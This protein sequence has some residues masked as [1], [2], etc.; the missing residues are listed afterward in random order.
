MALISKELQIY[1]SFLIESYPTGLLKLSL[2]FGLLISFSAK[3]DTLNVP[4][5]HATVN[6][7]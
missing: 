5:D 6:T 2:I 3:A 1:F 7:P 4:E